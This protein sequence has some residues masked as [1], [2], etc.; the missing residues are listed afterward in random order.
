MDKAEK[1]FNNFRLA[2]QAANSVNDLLIVVSSNFSDRQ[3]IN[4]EYAK[5][6]NKELNKLYKGD[7][8]KKKQHCIRLV[9]IA[10]HNYFSE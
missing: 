1:H 6:L 3:D 7:F 4:E 10:E 5:R 9:N 8:D 2:V